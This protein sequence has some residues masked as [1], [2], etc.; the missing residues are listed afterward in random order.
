MHPTII[1]SASPFHLQIP[2]HACTNMHPST[3]HCMSDFINF[4]LISSSQ[5]NGV[6]SESLQAIAP[7]LVIF[8]PCQQTYRPAHTRICH[9]FPDLRR[10]V[11]LHCAPALCLTRSCCISVAK[12]ILLWLITCTLPRVN[13]SRFLVLCVAGSSMSVPAIPCHALP[14]P[15]PPCHSLPLPTTPCPS[16]AHAFRCTLATS[17]CQSCCRRCRHSSQSFVPPSCAMSTGAW[18]S[19]CV[20]GWGGAGWG[21]AEQGRGKVQSYSGIQQP[22]LQLRGRTHPSYQCFC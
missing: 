12:C 15:A 11:G 17:S 7:D 2:C 6:R 19:L 20:W 10:A 3:P 1:S 13:L 22:K 14:H 21:G 16:L 4:L 9:P 5:L 18:P 8:W